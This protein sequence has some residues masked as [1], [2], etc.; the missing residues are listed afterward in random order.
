MV[1]AAECDHV[2][3]IEPTITRAEHIGAG[4]HGGVEDGIVLGIGQNDRRAHGWLNDAGDRADIGNMF[5]DFIGG[6]T[7]DALQV[8]VAER[9][10]NLGQ[11]ER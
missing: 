7:K 3:E 5:V 10:A 2:G 8:R 4:T 9:L 6:N 1:A 11:D